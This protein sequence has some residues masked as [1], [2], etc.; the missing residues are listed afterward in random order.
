MSEKQMT[1]QELYDEIKKTSKDAFILEEMKRLGFWD[2][3]KPKVAHELIE[4]KVAL[5]KELNGLSTK[6]RNPEAVI[7]E[8]HKQRM[9]DALVRREE[10]KAKREAKE[11]EAE[12]QRK[13][14][15]EN[16]IGFIGSSFIN[17]LNKQ[18]SNQ[19]LLNGNN[20]FLIK[21]VKV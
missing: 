20:L 4:K 11:Q 9:A 17:D 21:N 18:D 19:E 12:Q 10:T 6:I 15:K 13:E 14:K 1:R 16:A 7:K 2:S 3:S 8:I 5:Q